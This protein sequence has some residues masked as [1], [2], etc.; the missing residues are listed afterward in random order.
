ML[1]LFRTQVNV[2]NAPFT[3]GKRYYRNPD[4]PFEDAGNGESN[5]CC[6]TVVVENDLFQ[7]ARSLAGAI[8]NL[9]INI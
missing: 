4:H 8:T 3:F 5:L 2:E 9:G 1:D 6:V 7:M